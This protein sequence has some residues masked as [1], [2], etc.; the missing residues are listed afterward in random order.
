MTGV[1]LPEPRT[2]ASLAAELGGDVDAAA[3]DLVVTRVA[4]IAGAG[5]GDLVPI[6]SSRGAAQ[7]A[8]CAGV[9]LVERS[10]ADRVAAGRRWVS[11]HAAWA[12]ASLLDGLAPRWASAPRGP[13]HVEPGAD[14]APDAVLGPGAV[15]LA[16]AV[17]GAATSVG[18]NAVV[19]GG[20]TLGRRVVVGAGAVLGRPGFGWVAGPDGARRRMPQLGGV[21]VEDD[22]EIGP[23]ATVDAGTLGPTVLRRGVKLDAQVHVGHNVEIGEATIVAA[24]TGFAGSV[25]VGQGVQVGGQVGV[26]DHV[27]LGAFARI[28]AKSGVIGDVPAGRTVAGYPAV[29]RARW[30]RGMARLLR[31]G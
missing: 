7:A 24:Q 8:G 3:A 18:P 16:G 2:L 31:R 20:V 15:V 5:P 13:A 9:L 30:L 25:R 29:D 14:V 10:L 17:I 12:L 4:P 26:A 6:T 19:Y 1:A 23:L 21:V 28:A 27:T 11:P 22:V